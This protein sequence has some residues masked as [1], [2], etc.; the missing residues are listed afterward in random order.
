MQNIL[1]NIR[2]RLYRKE[3]LFDVSSLFRQRNIYFNHR[4]CIF[5]L[6]SIISLGFF[7]FP[8]CP[9]NIHTCLP[10]RFRASFEL[11]QG[12]CLARLHD[13]EINALLASR[14]ICRANKWSE[15]RV[16]SCRRLAPLSIGCTLVRQDNTNVF[17]A[18]Q[19]FWSC[20]CVSSGSLHNSGCNCCNSFPIT[21]NPL[22]C[23]R[24]LSRIIR[25]IA[26]ACV[27]NPPSP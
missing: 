15:T 2:N 27:G 5:V 19:M 7:R 26:P 14:Q 9:P 8:T 13:V 23:G 20:C 11:R 22:F 12:F 24:F 1:T 6:Q 3:I 21:I 17:G 4:N 10:N 25:R 18:G 16:A